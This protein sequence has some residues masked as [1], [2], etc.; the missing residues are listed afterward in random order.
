MPPVELKHRGNAYCV[1]Y[2]VQIGDELLD[3]AIDERERI[4]TARGAPLPCVVLDASRAPFPMAD[5]ALSNRIALFDLGEP[6]WRSSFK[7]WAE[8]SRSV[9]C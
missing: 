9:A 8:S 2:A 7:A 5:F 3:I 6:A 1:L 4:N